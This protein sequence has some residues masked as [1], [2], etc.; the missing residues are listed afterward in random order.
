MSKDKTIEKLESFKKL[1]KGWNFGDGL[2]IDRSVINHAKKLNEGLRNEGFKTD[3]FPGVD[4]TVTLDCYM[5]DVTYEFA[6]EKDLSI[7][8]EIELESSIKV[9]V[10]NLKRK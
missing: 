4:G 6:I 8:L 1:T 5:D 9:S 10:R 3:A 7:N 2:P